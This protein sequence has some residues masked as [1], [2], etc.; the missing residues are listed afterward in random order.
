MA[1]RY[2]PQIT[3]KLSIV[4]LSAVIMI[5]GSWMVLHKAKSL[6]TST[7][8]T[9]GVILLIPSI[10]ILAITNSLNSHIL[11]TL[12]GGIFGFLFAKSK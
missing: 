5:G 12:L 8:Q 11:A 2:D 4:A 10:L 9:I 7:L 3:L 1:V 6:D